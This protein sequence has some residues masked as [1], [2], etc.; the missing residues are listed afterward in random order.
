[1][2]LST[3]ETTV[4]DN[5][6]ITMEHFYKNGI[7]NIYL[8][9]LTR[10]SSYYEVVYLIDRIQVEQITESDRIQFQLSMSDIDDH[11][12]QLT[13]C[14][15]DVQTNLIYKKTLING[16]LKLFQIIE[17]IYHIL[18]KLELSGHPDYQLRDEHYEI[19]L[20]QSDNAIQHRIQNLESIYTTLKIAYDI[21]IQNLP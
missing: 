4:L 9:H 18:T 5:A 7:V 13:F 17:N 1:M 21:W 8:Q 15:V 12:R 11:K 6:L 10:K 19:H 3:E 16:Q 2:W 14:N 20:E